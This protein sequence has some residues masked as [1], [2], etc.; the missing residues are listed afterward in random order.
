MQAFQLVT[1]VDSMHD[2]DQH[3]DATASKLKHILQGDRCGAPARLTFC[4]V[5]VAAGMKY[6]CA[7]G[8]AAAAADLYC[9]AFPTSI[10]LLAA[11]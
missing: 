6:C 4:F 9:T 3:A 11:S 5:R 7:G 1:T 8:V 2:D 10:L